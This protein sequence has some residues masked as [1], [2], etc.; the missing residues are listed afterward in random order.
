MKS[1]SIWIKPQSKGS[2]FGR[3]T[4]LWLICV[5]CLCASAQTPATN[6]ATAVTNGP[7]RLVEK[8][9]RLSS[10][11]LMFDLDQVPLLR[12]HSFLGEPLWKYVASVIYLF[13]AFYVSKVIDYVARVWLG[14]VAARTET[15]LDDLLLKLLRG[16]IKVVAFVLLLNVGL[17]FFDWSPTARL[18]L[19]KGLIIV[20]AASL[21]YLAIKVLALLLQN[22]RQRHEQ[23]ADARFD[24]QL[25]SVIRISLNTFIIIVA[26][27]VTAQNMDINITAALTSLSIGGLAVGL[28]AQDTLGNLFGAVA[29]FM[30]RP[31]RV[32]DQIRLDGAEGTVEA[33]GLRSTRVRNPDGCLV[34]VPNKTM[35][36][37]IVTN[38]S[39][40]PNIKTVMNFTLP[41][42]IPAPKLKR[43]VA[44]LNEVYRGHPMTKDVWVSFNQFTVDKLN[45]MVVHWWKDTDYKSYLAGIQEMNLAVKE[46]FDAEEIPLG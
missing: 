40:R 19:S 35:G 39:R 44:V 32:G 6:Q 36:N 30:D 21:T 1:L 28:A 4:F 43:A 16:P 33:V 25:F 17:N 3:L 18:Y 34:A 7:S 5:G 37:A 10:R 29:V 38:L 26:V 15:K 22:W 31:F 23:E 20:V 12:E 14:K 8:V 42:S 41:R 27:L 9:E 11:P 2:L 13:L 46:K 45:I 24:D